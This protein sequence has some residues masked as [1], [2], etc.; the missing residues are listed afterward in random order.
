[1]KFE[2]QETV[3]G[4]VRGSNEWI[5]YK[6]IFRV[7]DSGKNPVSLEL[8]FVPPHPFVMNMPENKTLK[9]ESIAH[10]FLKLVHFF[11]QLGVDFR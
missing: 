7:K 8:K 1:M 11:D 6:A 3:R 5:E 4:R 2:S 9:A 10:V